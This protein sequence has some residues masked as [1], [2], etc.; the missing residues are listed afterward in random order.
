MY[1]TALARLMS[2]ILQRELGFRGYVTV[3]TTVS[4]GAGLAEKGKGKKNN[5]NKPMLLRSR[6]SC[7]L[8]RKGGREG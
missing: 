2:M 6:E 7:V 3:D 5:A 1:C 4:K 8:E